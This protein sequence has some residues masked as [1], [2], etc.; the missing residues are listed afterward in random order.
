MRIES[1]RLV[2]CAY[3]DELI[4]AT[5]GSVSSAVSVCCPVCYREY[6]EDS[7]L[8]PRILHCGHSFCT[9]S[10][11]HAVGSVRVKSSPSVSLYSCRVPTETVG[12]GRR[13]ERGRR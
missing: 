5:C 2:A 8:V 6:S 7:D 10:R 13:G 9:G 12:R 4:M 3:C 1:T 11:V